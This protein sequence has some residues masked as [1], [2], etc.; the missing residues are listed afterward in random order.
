MAVQVTEAFEMGISQKSYSGAEH[1][2]GS[3]TCLGSKLA[4]KLGVRSQV[5]S[6]GIGGGKGEQHG[7][8]DLEYGYDHV[9]EH[10]R[11]NAQGRLSSNAN[12]FVPAGATNRSTMEQSENI[13][14]LTENIIQRTVDFTLTG[15]FLGST[16]AVLPNSKKKHQNLHFHLNLP[17]VHPTSPCSSF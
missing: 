1:L 15:G 3:R 13:K 10:G 14:A 6:L 8:E 5:R 4:S 9:S 16:P 11:G 2:A 12:P 17:L 7:L